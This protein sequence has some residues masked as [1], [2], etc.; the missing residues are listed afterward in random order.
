MG[1]DQEEI[2]PTIERNFTTKF[3]IPNEYSESILI[4]D[5]DSFLSDRTSAVCI[6]VDMSFNTTQ[7]VLKL[8]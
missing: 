4:T 7:V 2:E 6:T 1:L 8:I 3:E 5:S